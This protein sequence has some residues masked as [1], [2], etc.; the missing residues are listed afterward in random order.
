MDTQYRLFDVSYRNIV[1]IDNNVFEPSIEPKL[2]IATCSPVIWIAIHLKMKLNGYLD[3]NTEPRTQM[4][5]PLLF[6][7]HLQLQRSFEDFIF[8]GD[9]LV[10]FVAERRCIS[11]IFDMWN[12]VSVRQWIETKLGKELQ[13][14]H[15]QYRWWNRFSKN[16]F[17]DFLLRYD[18]IVCFLAIQ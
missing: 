11:Y 9:V 18:E 10:L 14:Q 6:Q 16:N 17:N 8:H 7:L 4:S 15:L 1:R 3:L 13:L 12:R 5:V 2:D